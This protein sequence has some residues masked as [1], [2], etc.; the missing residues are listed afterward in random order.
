MIAYKYISYVGMF[1]KTILVIPTVYACVSFM[2][3]ENEDFP[4]TINNSMYAAIA[5]ISIPTI[6]LLFIN[7]VNFNIFLREN[8]PFS[9]LPFVCSITQN[10]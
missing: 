2:V 1:T 3:A 6:M 10:D 9:Q 7:I 4:F 8:N 5:A